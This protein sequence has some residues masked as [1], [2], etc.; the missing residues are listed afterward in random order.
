[1]PLVCCRRGAKAHRLLGRLQVSDAAGL[2]RYERGHHW[3]QL[4]FRT[5]RGTAV[6]K[7]RQALLMSTISAQRY[8]ESI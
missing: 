6:L 4:Y 8:G 3:M 7:Y 1:M 5:L 2:R